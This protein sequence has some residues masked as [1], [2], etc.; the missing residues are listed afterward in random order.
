MT[1]S[2]ISVLLVAAVS[3][4]SLFSCRKS[5]DTSADIT[6]NY[7]PLQ[8]GKTV[9]YAVDSTYYIGALR[10]AYN[11]KSQ[12][13]YAITDTFTDK[14]K[15]VSYIMNVFSRPYD[16]ALWQ[17]I[18][19][20]T[21]TP[22][23]TGLLYNQDDNEYIKMIFP[24]SEGLTW[25]GNQNV[26]VQ[27]PLKSY[28]KNWNYKYQNY[29]LSYN[30]GFINFDNTVSVLENDESVNYPNVDSAVD[31]FRTYAKEVYAY[32]VGMVYK[33]W[34]HWTYKPDTVQYVNGYRVVMRAIDHN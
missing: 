34:T 12:M 20:I 6:R 1:K 8:R 26:V 23:T 22:T 30:T 18:S 19:V 2:I 15:R 9:T 32:N 21:V 14:K 13:K 28:L 33:E 7:F 10:I 27:D 16:G 4:T 17:P 25:K 5:N 11:V 31:A 3:V 29:H 24:V